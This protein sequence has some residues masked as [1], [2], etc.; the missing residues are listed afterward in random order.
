LNTFQRELLDMVQYTDYIATFADK[1]R[2]IVDIE[3]WTYTV[4]G[5][6]LP[7]NITQTVSQSFIT[8]MAGDADFVLT[9]ISGFARSAANP[10]GP[11]VMIINP[12]ILVQIADQSTGRT[13]FSGPAPMAMMAGQGGF[14]FLLTSPHIIHARS[15][16]KTTAIAAQAITF[17]GFFMCYHGARIWYGN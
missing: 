12:A 8:P 5:N 14:P 17:T 6:V 11:Q 15:S 16:L 9:A 2:N 4:D 7:A 10:W 13:F 3:P 1:T